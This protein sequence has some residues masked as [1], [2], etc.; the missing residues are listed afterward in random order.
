MKRLS[1]A[2]DGCAHILAG[3]SN[4]HRLRR[5]GKTLDQQ[6]AARLMHSLD[7]WRRTNVGELKRRAL[8]IQR[9]GHRRGWC[10]LMT[11]K[12]SGHA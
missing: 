9:G 12:F 5:F 2:D 8:E 3:V 1:F 6:P 7:A 4:F 11:L 10:K